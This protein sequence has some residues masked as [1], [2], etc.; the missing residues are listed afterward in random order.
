M[1]HGY[2]TKHLAFD[3][4]SSL[5]PAAAI[6]AV[7]A[8]EHDDNEETDHDDLQDVHELDPDTAAAMVS[9][10]KEAGFTLRPH[11]SKASY[12]QSSVESSIKSVKRI[13]KASFLPGLQGMTAITFS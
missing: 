13:L 7:A 8:A 10:L 3:A 9:N 11:Y 6:T 5:L 12:R 1:E 4:G 2:K